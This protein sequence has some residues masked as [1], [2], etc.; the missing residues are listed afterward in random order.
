MNKIIWPW[1]IFEETEGSDKIH[2]QLLEGQMR[3]LEKEGTRLYGHVGRQEFSRDQ[4]EQRARREEGEPNLAIKK[5]G[6]ME[7]MRS[8]EGWTYL[9]S[10]ERTRMVD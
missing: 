2:A 1:Q 9:C 5:R 8:L 4:R 10:M 7:E 3:L 6:T